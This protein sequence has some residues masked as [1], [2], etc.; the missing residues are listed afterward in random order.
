MAM[1]F[2]T[3]SFGR[4]AAGSFLDGLVLAVPSGVAFA[5]GNRPH[6]WLYVALT[7]LYTIG[8]TAASGQTLGKRIVGTRVVVD[9]AST[10]AP[11]RLDA[12]VVRWAVLA[13]PG[14]LPG[15]LGAVASLA[16][17]LIAVYGIANDER[18]RGI[19]D[20]IARTRV[21]EAE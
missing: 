15:P 17:V 16:I 1:T 2:R 3:A 18:A 6:P 10:A 13:V 20:N 7:A 21:V 9:D 11:P 19:H 5:L 8:L 12:C 4:R 14:L